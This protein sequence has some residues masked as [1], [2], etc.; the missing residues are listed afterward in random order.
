VAP[1]P[2]NPELDHVSID[3]M[4]V[5]LGPVTMRSMRSIPGMS[6]LNGLDLKASGLVSRNSSGISK[7][8]SNIVVR[9]NTQQ[10]NLAANGIKE[11]E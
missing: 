8:V 9:R 11:W 1:S 2:Q 7:L 6:Y 10:Q 5:F 4:W 3:E